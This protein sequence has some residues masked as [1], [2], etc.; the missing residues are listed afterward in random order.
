MVSIEGK[1]QAKS[2]GD[3]EARRLISNRE[4]LKR[5]HEGDRVLVGP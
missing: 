4:D 1:V 3:M 2:S 5:F